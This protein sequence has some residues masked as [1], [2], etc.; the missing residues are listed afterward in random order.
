[1]TS[2]TDQA[3]QHRSDAYYK[4]VEFCRAS[5]IYA[6]LVAGA[7]VFSWPF[8]WMATTSVKVD[9]EM[10]GEKIRLMPRRPIPAVQSPY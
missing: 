5:W 6:L 3:P 2:V 7:I 10:F 4:F 9:R 1:M 8:L